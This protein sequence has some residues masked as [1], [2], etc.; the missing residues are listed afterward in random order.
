MCACLALGALLLMP[1]EARAER[2]DPKQ[3][4]EPLRPWTSWVLDG[5]QEALCPA[6]QGTPEL[7]RCAWPTGLTLV[8]GDKGGRFEQRW[9]LDARAWV[10]LP[11][12]DSRW[13]LD[14][15]AGAQKLVVVAHAAAPSVQLE[16]GD[17]TISG[18]FAWDSLP[19]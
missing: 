16:P 4:P 11:G 15:K 10:P 3:A 13:P 12:D 1:F 6:F 2:L 5:K 19:D 18:T 14:V 7:V 17:H 9:H 8:L